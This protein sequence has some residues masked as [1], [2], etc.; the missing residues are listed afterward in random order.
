[1]LEVLMT[2]DDYYDGYKFFVVD[3]AT[4]QTEFTEETGVRS[5]VYFDVGNMDNQGSKELLVGFSNYDHHYELPQKILLLDAAT[6]RQLNEF[7][8]NNQRDLQCLFFVE[9]LAASHGKEIAMVSEK[10]SVLGSQQFN[11]LWSTEHYI[12]R[13]VA[14]DIDND[15]Q[16][17]IV[18]LGAEDSNDDG[19]VIVYAAASGQIE[20]ESMPLEG[21]VSWMEIEDIDNDGTLEI[22]F[23]VS[24]GISILNGASYSYDWTYSEADA[25]CLDFEDILPEIPGT[26]I[27]YGTGDN[28]VYV[29]NGITHE[30]IYSFSLE[31][32]SYPHALEVADIDKD[33]QPEIILVSANLITCTDKHGNILSSQSVSG[34]F[35]PAVKQILCE[36]INDD[37]VNEILIATAGILY[38][39]RYGEASSG[40]GSGCDQTGVTLELSS[41][42]F[43]SDELFYLFADICNSGDHVLK[44]HHIMVILDAYGEYFCIPSWINTKDGLD[45][46][47]YPIPSGRWELNAV[48][49]FYWPMVQG[50][51]NGLRFYGAILD[52][53][54]T[55]LVGEM[56]SIDFGWNS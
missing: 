15:G 24:G 17:E 47:Q 26:E 6:H 20:F 30:E 13:A 41:D 16:T 38:E 23:L 31:G 48:P 25:K 44:N 1:V 27:I 40:P 39:F 50:S 14:A 37:G 55:S 29:Y 19:H 5:P 51:A 8:V 52:P 35:S 9:A 45:S 28:N 34:D 53:G 12:S 32:D 2:T 10:L 56:D 36:D 46:F 11:E 49:Y 33:G 18:A 54:M 22:G 21:G 43:Q 4:R 3:S 7:E 42:T